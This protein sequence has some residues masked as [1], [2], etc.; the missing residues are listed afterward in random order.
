MLKQLEI[1]L[2]LAFG[3]VK[4]SLAEDLLKDLQKLHKKGASKSE[5]RCLT[6]T[7]FSTEIEDIQSSY[8]SVID[9]LWSER[10]ERR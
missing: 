5:A 10:T 7:V 4:K 2:S 3:K 8:N 6:T 1:C 9:E